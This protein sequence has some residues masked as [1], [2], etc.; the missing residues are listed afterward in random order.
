M[1]KAAEKGLENNQHIK[2]PFLELTVQIW[3]ICLEVMKITVELF[4]IN[5]HR[6]M[7]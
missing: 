7:S 5:A 6:K 4:Q 3:S 2:I 1:W